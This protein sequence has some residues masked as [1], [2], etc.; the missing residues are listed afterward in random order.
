MRKMEGDNRGPDNGQINL[1]DMDNALPDP[2]IIV[3]SQEYVDD[4][5]SI[6]SHSRGGSVV[7]DAPEDE[8]VSTCL[9]S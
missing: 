9:F 8:E 1:T 4:V 7:A 6:A 3:P 2:P 5:M